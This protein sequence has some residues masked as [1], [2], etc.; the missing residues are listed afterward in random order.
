MLNRFRRKKKYSLYLGVLAVA[1]RSDLKRNFD[2]LSL[3][4]REDLDLSLQ[5]QLVEV[6]DLPLA[7]TLNQPTELDLGLDV[8]VP[9]FQLGDMLDVSLGDIGFS[10]FWRP[11]VEVVARIYRLDTGATLHTASATAKLS[12]KQYFSRLFTWRALFRF[13]PMFDSQDLNVLLQ[14]SCLE[15][16]VKLRKVA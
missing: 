10:L 12:W 3:W 7:S 5:K 13:K 16:L 8:I 1:P 6:F 11:K 2:E 9:K 14:R 4:G 15:L